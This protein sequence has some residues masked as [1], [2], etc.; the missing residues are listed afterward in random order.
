VSSEPIFLQYH[1]YDNLGQEIKLQTSE[2]E[3]DIGVLVDEQLSFSKHM[4]QQINK[5]NSIINSRHD[6]ESLNHV[7]SVSP[8]F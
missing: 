1:L 3:K 5:A 8:V 4:Q 2:G 7:S 6:L